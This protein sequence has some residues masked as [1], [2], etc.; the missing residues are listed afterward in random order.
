MPQ[1]HAVLGRPAPTNLEELGQLSTDEKNKFYIEILRMRRSTEWK[2]IIAR[3]MAGHNVIQQAYTAWY[4]D[5][6]A[7]NQEFARAGLPIDDVDRLISNRLDDAARAKLGATSREMHARFD[8]QPP[9]TA[10]YGRSWIR[11]RPTFPST[12]RRF[13]RTRERVV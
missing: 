12:S 7:G 2:Q 6:E 10:D 13:P 9:S 11:P 8:D 3:F 1:L 5:R 4:H